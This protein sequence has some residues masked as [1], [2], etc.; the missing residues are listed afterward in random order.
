MK[1]DYSWG[2]LLVYGI[3]GSVVWL[4]ELVFEPFVFE[5]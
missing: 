2:F 4:Y 1:I 5:L 3:N